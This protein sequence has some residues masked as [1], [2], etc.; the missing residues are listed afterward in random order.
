MLYHGF[1][2]SIVSAVFLLSLG[3][4]ICAI[5]PDKEPAPFVPPANPPFDELD[6][7]TDKVI[8]LHSNASWSP[9]GVARDLAKTPDMMWRPFIVYKANELVWD[10]IVVRKLYR[11]RMTNANVKPHTAPEAWADLSDALE[12]AKE[13]PCWD[14][15]VGFCRVWSAD[16]MYDTNVV[17]RYRA[18][19]YKAIE[20][21]LGMTPNSYT[22]GWKRVRCT[23]T[24]CVDEAPVCNSGVKLWSLHTSYTAGDCVAAYQKTTVVR[25]GQP[26]NVWS[27]T[28]K[29]YRAAVANRNL[30]PTGHIH[31]HEGWIEV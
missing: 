22:K 30:P 17:V 29:T 18:A 15:D 4:A 16:K 26:I 13:T 9:D 2:F 28:T 25:N 24:G 21:S 23:A 14:E 7:W 12:H 8:R 20:A 5:G 19:F 6:L 1:S 3:L 31:S 11:A 27:S 10:G